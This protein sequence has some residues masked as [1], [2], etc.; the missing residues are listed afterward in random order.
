MKRLLCLLLLM[1]LPGFALGEVVTFQKTFTADTSATALD[2]GEM[3]VKKLDAFIE[4]L[5]Q[6]P[7]LQQVDMF[8]TRVYPASMDKLAQAFPQV[9]FGWTM[10]IGDHW[11]RTD[12]T[13]FSTLHGNSDRQHTEEDFRYLKYCRNLL[14]LDIGHNAVRDVSFLYDLPKLKVLILA[15]NQIEDITP[16]GSLTELEYLE[17]FKN[18]I[19]DISPVQHC[20]KLLDLNICFNH[21]SDWSALEGLDRLERLWLFNSNN[22]SDKDPVPQEAIEALKA[23]LPDCQIDSTSYSTLGGWRDHKRYYVV[24]NMFKY[25]EYVPFYRGK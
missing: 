14:A 2:L 18:D 23:A 6:F 19:L 8:A 9:E 22:W 11:V 17:L 4:Y 15:C 1:L 20:T 16:V 10:R 13:A 7:N 12:A 5:G 24:Y 21:I 25:S 3:Q